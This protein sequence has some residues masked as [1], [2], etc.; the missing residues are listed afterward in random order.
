MTLPPRE[1]LRRVLSQVLP[2]GLHKVRYF[3]WLHPKAKKRYAK[4]ATLVEAILVLTHPEPP[5]PPLHLRCPHCQAFALEIV[6]RL[7]R[8]R[9]P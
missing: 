5:T 3:G 6:G 2:E 4:V 7:P 9:P 8:P 1:F